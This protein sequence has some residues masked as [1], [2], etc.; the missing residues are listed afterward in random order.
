M[1]GFQGTPP[2]P[3]PQGGFYPRTLRYSCRVGSWSSDP[4]WSFSSS[5]EGPVWPTA[6]AAAVSPAARTVAVPRPARL[7]PTATPGTVSSPAKHP[8]GTDGLRSEPPGS[9]ACSAAWPRSQRRDGYGRELQRWELPHRPS[10]HQHSSD[11]ATRP[12]LSCYGQ[13]RFVIHLSIQ[14]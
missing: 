6:A 2:P 8:S 5:R 13:A 3:Q 14:I 7:L 9:A 12:R 1:S 4:L 11:P 10:R